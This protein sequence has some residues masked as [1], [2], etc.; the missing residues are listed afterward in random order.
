M[1]LGVHCALAVGIKT[2]PKPSGKAP[3]DKEGSGS[4]PQPASV[5][6]QRA[7]R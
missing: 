1:A 7:S 5:G 2:D 6:T 4:A 3:K